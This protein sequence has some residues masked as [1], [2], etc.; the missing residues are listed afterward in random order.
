MTLNRQSNPEQKDQC[1]KLYLK[2]YCSDIKTNQPWIHP[3]HKLTHTNQWYYK[4]LRYT[5]SYRKIYLMCD[6]G[7]RND[8]LE[9]TQLLFC[10]SILLKHYL[11]NSHFWKTATNKQPLYFFIHLNACMYKSVVTWEQYTFRQIS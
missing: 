6:R 10:V 5:S 8:S 2:L 3:P 11:K 1:W 9:E 7:T 4:S